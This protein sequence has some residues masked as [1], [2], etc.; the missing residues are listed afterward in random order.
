MG[1]GIWAVEASACSMMEPW[2]DVWVHTCVHVCAHWRCLCVCTCADLCLST[3][4]CASDTPTLPDLSSESVCSAGEVNELLI[5]GVHIRAHLDLR[6][7]GRLAG[8]GV[9]ERTAR[10]LLPAPGRVD[11]SSAPSL[12]SAPLLVCLKLPKP[13]ASRAL[14]RQRE[15]P[16]LPSQAL[17]WPPRRSAGRR[18]SG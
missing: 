14:C 7:T 13:P 8:E 17:A 4:G 2:R 6:Q 12:L 18:E 9:G 10:W 16:G 11:P 1:P 5:P 3:Q 15:R